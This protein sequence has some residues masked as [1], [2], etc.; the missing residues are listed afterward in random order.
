MSITRPR[1]FRRASIVA[2]M[3]LIEMSI[4]VAVI[5]VGLF[6]LAGWF[7]S[8]RQGARV[9]LA[10]RMLAELDRCLARYHRSTG[11]FPRPQ[12]PNAANWATVALLDHEKARP[13][14]EAFPDSLWHGPGKKNLVDPW[15]TPLRYD[16]PEPRADAR[17]GSAGRAAAGRPVFISAGP[18]RDFG[19]TDVSKV[20]DNLRSDDPGP[21][22]F[23]LHNLIEDPTPETT[24]PHGEKAD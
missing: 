23:R 12:G 16:F 1:T 8:M 17:E 9:D 18:D 22:G 24:E 4:A 5:G 15:G 14:L 10:V 21:D 3:T 11:T 13:T 2:G 20:G 7:G 19:D 6:L